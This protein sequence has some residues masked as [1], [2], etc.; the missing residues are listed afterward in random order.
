MALLGAFAKAGRKDRREIFFLFLHLYAIFAVDTGR[1]VL[2][3]SPFS[4]FFSA[5]RKPVIKF[6]FTNFLLWRRIMS[7]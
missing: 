1:I 3:L 4:W 5:Y 2:I 6:Y 7:L